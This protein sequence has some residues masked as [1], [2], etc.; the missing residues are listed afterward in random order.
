MVFAALI[1]MSCSKNGIDSGM[2]FMPEEGIYHGEIILGDQLDNPYKLENMQ[3]AYDVVSLTKG[4]SSHSR[5]PLKP[6]HLYVRFLP[7]TDQEYDDLM[8]E[9]LDLVDHPLDYSI[10]RE[11]DWYHDPEIPAGECTWL[12]STVP[13]DFDFKDYN[14][15]ELQECVIQEV[16]AGTRSYGIDWAEVERMAFEMTGNSNEICDQIE[17]RSGKEAFRPS[18]RITIEDTEWNGGVPFGVAGVRVSCN[19]FV[20]FAHT[21]TDRDGYYTM[22]KSF[23]S[24]PRYRLVF[25]NEKGF[26]IGFNAIIVPASVSTLGK[27][28][29]SGKSYTVNINSDEKLFRRC[30]VNNAAYDYICQCQDEEG[31]NIPLPPSNLRIWIFKSAKA[32]SA[33]MLHHGALL[34][35]EH[36]KGYLGALAF[37]VKSFAPD[38]TIGT[39][40]YHTYS[41]IYRTVVHEMAHTSHYAQVGNN[42]WN[43]YIVYIINSFIHDKTICYGN[44]L[45]SNAG[46]CEIGEMWAYYMESLLVQNRY[47]GERI[48]FGYTFWFYPQIFHQLD[49]YGLAPKNFLLALQGD[50]T[51][52]ISLRDKL[53]YLYGDLNQDW[54]E[55]IIEVFD[56]YDYVRE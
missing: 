37:V 9:K 28:S 5:E 46:Y 35:N 15:E 39:E 29:P 24:N 42:Y 18:G 43:K 1:V 44:G 3:A 32:S 8:N 25:K 19:C 12:Y 50:V 45:G 49:N 20:K 21:Y 4:G 55:H 38:I 52:L 33:V 27:G 30:V 16:E 13:V 2:V 48:P 22:D 56:K 23:R 54:K 11:G 6:T 34:T 31:L 51:N 47:G 26:A 53:L 14:Y 10:K 36:I 17:T 40:G 7:L 41:E